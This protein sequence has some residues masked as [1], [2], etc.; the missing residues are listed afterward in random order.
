MTS[1]R[2]EVEQ[3][4]KWLATARAVCALRGIELHQLD[5]DADLEFIV[6]CG[7]F[8]QSTATRPQLIALLRDLGVELPDP[9]GEVPA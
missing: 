2:A 9:P 8:T 6:T 5:G 4:D 1:G 7:P 3:L